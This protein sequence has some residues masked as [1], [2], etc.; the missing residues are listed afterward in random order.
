MTVSSCH[1]HYPL[2]CCSK[3]SVRHDLPNPQC[4]DAL[5]ASASPAQVPVTSEKK[6]SGQKVV[7]EQ[8]SAEDGKCEILLKS[9]LKTLKSPDSERIL[10]GNVK[11]MDS[12]G[13]ELVEVKEFEPTE[14]EESEDYTD[15]NIGCV[16]VIQ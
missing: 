13:K 11:W 2:V 14:S 7:I 3:S 16:C 4:G 15:D 1:C 12:S 8:K 6:P 9:S 10:K 5:Q